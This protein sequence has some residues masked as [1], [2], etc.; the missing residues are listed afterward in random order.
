MSTYLLAGTAIG[1]V[2]G[3]LHMLCLFAARFGRTGLTPLKTLW[4]GVWIWAL[5]TVF[6]AYVLSFWILGLLCLGLSRLMFKNI[7]A[8]R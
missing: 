1:A 2:I 4:H 5:W 8:L 7:S 3:F 6:G